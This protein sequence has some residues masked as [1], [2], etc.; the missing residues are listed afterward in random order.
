MDLF[1]QCYK[2]VVSSTLNNW[3]GMLRNDGCLSSYLSP[4]WIL[5]WTSNQFLTTVGVFLCWRR[6]WLLHGI[7]SQV[8]GC[9][10]LHLTWS[11][12]RLCSVFD[13]GNR[14]IVK[15]LKCIVN[16]ETW[17][18]LTCDQVISMGGGGG[19]RKIPFSPTQKRKKS[20][21]HRLGEFQLISP[22]R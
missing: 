15:E 7:F 14:W 21:D 3:P 2:F 1:Y 11:N 17:G 10:Y 19:R 12:H 9:L 22:V 4:H 16:I 5:H 8:H 20:P 6:L 13:M 18:I